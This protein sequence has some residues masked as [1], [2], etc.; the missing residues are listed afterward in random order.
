MAKETKATLEATNF[1][2]IT[3]LV[4]GAAEHRMVGDPILDADE[5]RSIEPSAKVTW[6]RAGAPLNA[7]PGRAR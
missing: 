2:V 6:S 5:L 4:P 3:D 1:D 7:S